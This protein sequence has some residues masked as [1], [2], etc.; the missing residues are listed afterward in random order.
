M[1]RQFSLCFYDVS[2]ST[3]L[4]LLGPPFPVLNDVLEYGSP[5]FSLFLS[6]KSGHSSHTYPHKL[7][8]SFSLYL[9]YLLDVPTVVLT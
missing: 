5:I 3:V 8:H 4:T 6:R 2:L 7:F 1:V 9:P